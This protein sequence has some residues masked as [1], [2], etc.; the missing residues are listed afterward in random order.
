[1][2][3]SPPW[4]AMPS[5]HSCLSSLAVLDVCAP[6][7]S[8]STPCLCCAAAW[9]QADANTPRPMS[10]RRHRSMPGEPQATVTGLTSSCRRI[11]T[12]QPPR[13]AAARL[14]AA[15]AGPHPAICCNQSSPRTP[16]LSLFMPCTAAAGHACMRKRKE[17]F[18]DSRKGAF[19][20]LA[21]DNDERVDRK[22]WIR[23]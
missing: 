20:V 14:R 9:P 18:L 22:F 15:A 5:H 21:R 12:S 2:A 11:S 1:M 6:L 10:R 13:A 8:P 7:S 17:A 23:A 16:P 4:V 3:T 19:A